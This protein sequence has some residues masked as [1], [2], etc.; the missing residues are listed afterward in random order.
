[1]AR[2]V[3]IGSLFTGYGGLLIYTHAKRYLRQIS[4]QLGTET[5][6]SLPI[7]DS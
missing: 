1:M 2:A 3:R 6:A 5:Q 4:I 7:R